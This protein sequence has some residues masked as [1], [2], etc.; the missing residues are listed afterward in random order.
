MYTS[1]IMPRKANPEKFRATATVRI[2][3]PILDKINEYCKQNN[4]S[5]SLFLST[6]ICENLPDLKA[7]K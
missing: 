4:L 3:R 1:M 7:P 6:I 5:R 2:E